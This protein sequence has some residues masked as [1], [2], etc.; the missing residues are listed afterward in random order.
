MY[1]AAMYRLRWYCWSFLRYG[2]RPSIIR[3]QWTKWRFST[4]M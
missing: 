3:I 4:F 1:F 2:S